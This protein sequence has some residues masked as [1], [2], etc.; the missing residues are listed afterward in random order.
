MPFSMAPAPWS[1]PKIHHHQIRHQ[2]TMFNKSG[3]FVRICHY[4]HSFC[5]TWRFCDIIKL[6]PSN[7]HHPLHNNWQPQDFLTANWNI[8]NLSWSYWQHEAVWIEWEGG[9][10]REYLP[11]GEENWS[12]VLDVE[13]RDNDFRMGVRQCLLSAVFIEKLVQVF[14]IIPGPE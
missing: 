11:W 14:R 4:A 12:L 5:C 7:M 2:L 9:M 3:L 1:E 13:R 6:R 10:V 8:G